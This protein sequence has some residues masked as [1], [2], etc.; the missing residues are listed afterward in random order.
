MPTFKLDDR[1]VPFEKG[2]T[3]LRAA[4]RQGIEIPHYCWHPGLSVAANCRMCLVELEPPPGRPAMML[5]IMHWD[6]EKRDW[7]PA[8]KPKL[9]PACQQEVSEGMVVRSQSSKHVAEARRSV[10]EFLLVNHPVDCPICDQAGEC[11]LQDYWMSEGR[12]PKR[13]LDEP[14]HK[15]KGVSFGETIVYDAE[16]CIACTRCIRVC[17]ELAGDHALD[18]RE[19]GNRF[20]VVLAPGRK[21]DGQYSLMTEHVCPVGA[22]TSSH[23]R[24]KARVWTLR[25]SPGVCTGCATGCNTWVDSDPR[26]NRVYRLRPR[27]NEQVNKYWMCDDGMLSYERQRVGRVFKATVGRDSGRAE[28]AVEEALKRAAT[29]LA[30]VPRGKLAVLLSAQATCE[31][32]LVLAELARAAGARLFLSAR[33][34]WE[35]DRILRSADANPNRA[36][37][38]LVGGEAVGSLKELVAAVAAGE[39]QAI[40]GAGA[41]ADLDSATLS[42]LGRVGTVALFLSQDGPL[43]RFATVTVPVCSSLETEG[44]FVNG[45]GLAQGFKRAVLPK[46]SVLPG[47]DAAARVGRG[48]GLD[49]AYRAVKEVRAALQARLVAPPGSAPGPGAGAD[50]GAEAAGT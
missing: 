37:A 28:V 2:D 18:L 38:L 50:G 9:Q 30:K 3:I 7:V 24:F 35:A 44:H 29:E 5:D 41:D 34:P 14:V 46:E 20:E 27:D 10:Q 32:N 12:Q 19:R 22:L 25:G 40:L 4:Y 21:L 43:A 11:K 36:G 26:E 6:A 16:R 8:R 23:F 17:D 15:P 39:V 49:L 31:D 13:M 48:L 47:W 42:P 33:G 45:K 1:E